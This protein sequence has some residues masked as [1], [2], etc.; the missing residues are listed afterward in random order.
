MQGGAAQAMPVCI[1]EEPEG[2]QRSQGGWIR[3]RSRWM[4]RKAG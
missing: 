2:A 1:V 4:V 3:R